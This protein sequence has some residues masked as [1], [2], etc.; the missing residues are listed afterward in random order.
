MASV[1][2]SLLSVTGFMDLMTAPPAGGTVHNVDPST[3]FSSFPNLTTGGTTTTVSDGDTVLFA[4]GTYVNKGLIDVSTNDVLFRPSSGTVTLVDNTWIRVEGNNNRFHAIDFQGINEQ[5]P[6][7]S[8]I[9]YNLEGSGNVV[10]QSEIV[11]SG[12]LGWAVVFN[13]PDNVIED[14]LIRGGNH[15]VISRGT[16]G[17]RN[18][19]NCVIRSVTIEELNNPG[20]GR[21]IGIAGPTIQGPPVAPNLSL[22]H[23]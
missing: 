8:G 4:P 9:R 12:S 16:F 23:I 22:I 5:T 20:F 11:T 18:I 2:S 3:D 17:T 15:G 19:S 7:S 1:P 10:T 6:G 13:G 21:A 14:S